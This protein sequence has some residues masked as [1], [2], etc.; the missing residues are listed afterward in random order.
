MGDA[1]LVARRIGTA[2]LIT[3]ASRDY[4][5][6]RGTPLTPADLAQHDCVVQ[7]GLTPGKRWVF[8][9]LDETVAV[10]ARGRFFSND[11]ELVRDS[12][13]DGMGITVGTEW[14]Y[15]DALELGRVR[16][17]LADY[18]LPTIPIHVAYASRRHL[19]ASVRAMINFLVDEFSEFPRGKPIGVS[20]GLAHVGDGAGVARR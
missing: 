17:L 5:A 12:V 16:A 7:V 10:D 4:L 6:R 8:E 2:R 15:T 1:S 14:L 13:L 20:L 9:R 19:P 11:A 18:E 3:V